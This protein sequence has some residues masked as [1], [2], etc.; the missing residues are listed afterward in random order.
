MSIFEPVIRAMAGLYQAT[1]TEVT[2]GQIRPTRMTARRAQIIGSDNR[3]FQIDAASINAASKTI[4]DIVFINLHSFKCGSTDGSNYTNYTNDAAKIA[5]PLGTAGFSNVEVM[6]YANAASYHNQNITMSV[7]LTPD[8]L[9]GSSN[10]AGK[11]A[12]FI[13]PQSAYIFFTLTNAGA[14]GQGGVVGGATAA[15]GAVYNIP[16]MAKAAQVILAFT[17]AGLPASG[18]FNTIMI[19]RTS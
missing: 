2:D 1:V 19:S 8:V 15:S 5:I 10:A 12:S 13:I 6:F 17:A 7:Y 18:A 14:V 16:A 3:S 4:N 9:G 11:A